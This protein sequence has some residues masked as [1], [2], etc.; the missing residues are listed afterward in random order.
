MP[1]LDGPAGHIGI[2]A[3]KLLRDLGRVALEEQ[4]GAVYWIRQRAAQH[5]FAARAC[6]PGLFEVRIPKLRAPGNVV[7]SNLVEQ[8]VMHARVS[9]L[10]G[11][12]PSAAEAVGIWPL[13]RSG[14]PLRHPKSSATSSSPAAC[15]TTKYFAAG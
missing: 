2:S 15:Y 5:Q 12:S 3:G 14:K 6:L 1:S 9:L 4:H 10:L 13:N 7:L 8:Q 11:R